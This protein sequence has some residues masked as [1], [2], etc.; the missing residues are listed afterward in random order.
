MNFQITTSKLTPEIE[1]EILEEFIQHSIETIGFDGFQKDY[2]SFVR[3]NI[4]EKD[5]VLS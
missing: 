5:L 3:K 1:K 2:I 4:E